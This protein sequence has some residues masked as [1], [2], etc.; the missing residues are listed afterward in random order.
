MKLIASGAYLQ[1]EFVSEV[2]LIPPSFLPIGN[3]RLYEYQV[4]FLGKCS[5]KNDDLYLSV[6]DS[7]EVDEYDLEK[8]KEL[9]VTL[10]KVPDGFSLGASLLYCWNAA[11]QH[12]NTFTLLHGDT[13]F[14]DG[15]Y[16]LEN[17]L[18]VH[19]NRGF[20][21]R[22]RLGEGV[23][24][25]Q[26]LNSDWSSNDEQVI[27][28]YFNFT[29]PLY[30]MKSLIQAK[31]DF[32][33]AIVNYHKDHP[34]TLV[35]SGVWLD[36]G[37]INS[38]FGSRTLMTTQRVFNE[39]KI[40]H[41]KVYKTS[42]NNPKKIFSEGSWFNQLPL[43]LRLHT[44]ALLKLEKG[45]ELFENAH[46]EI[47][48]LYLLPISDLF[49]FGRLEHGSWNVVF[50]A[51]SN[52]LKGFS[53]YKPSNISRGELESCDSLYL[54][55]TLERLKKYAEDSKCNI[56]DKVFLLSNGQQISLVDIAE[57][58][59]IFIKKTEEKD[60][61]ISHGDLCFSNMLFDSRAQ[62]IKCIDPRGVTS[63]GDFSLYG[64]KRYDLAKLYHSVIGLYDFI[65][66]ERFDLKIKDNNIDFF[67]ISL[68][69]ALQKEIEASF[70]E[71]ILS[72]SGYS[73][74]EILSI[75]IH[76]FLSMLPLHSDKPSRQK[77]F[78]ANA[79]RLFEK[80]EERT[81]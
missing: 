24:A 77:A 32:I 15:S 23:E 21:Q 31:N 59:S 49:V 17:S 26:L 18:S 46:Y 42:S 80:L 11:A 28:G 58:S 56:N 54:K 6:P 27:S 1:G 22:A 78:I 8:L 20:Y 70:R 35:N 36:F 48:Y 44:P 5:S 67:D 37:H 76:L 4:D 79:L 61:A 34:L 41:R 2:G 38:F 65:I 60:I 51:I 47:E 50:K 13:L 69:S 71:I 53:R 62:A 19:L 7:Y 33:C 43:S 45:N 3:K 81:L 64:D 72:V 12:Y 75:T 39:L 66:A 40:S 16:S 57:Y 14:L 52:V 29:Q 9:N 63:S 73:E 55:K 74:K 10:I 30:F 25:L 68:N